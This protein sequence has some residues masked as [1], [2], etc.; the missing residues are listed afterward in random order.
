MLNFL[1]TPVSW[2]LL[3]WHHLF[4]AVG[5]DKNGGLNWTLSIV[6]LVITARL[7]LFRLFIKQVKYQRHMQ[8]M[9]P[10]IQA[11]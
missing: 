3:Q 2:V 10:E 6:F 9:Q 7:L 4:N 8:V 5:L 1:Y 11:A